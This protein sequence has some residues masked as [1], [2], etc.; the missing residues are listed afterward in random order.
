MVVPQCDHNSV[1]A[2]SHLH[3]DEFLSWNTDGRGSSC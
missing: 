1:A 2:G 3:L